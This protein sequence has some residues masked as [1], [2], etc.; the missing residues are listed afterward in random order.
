MTHT[1]SVEC[2][3]VDGVDCVDCTDFMDCVDCVQCG[4]WGVY[5][6]CIG[7]YGLC[8]LFD[9]VECMHG[10][11]CGMC[12]PPAERKNDCILAF[13]RTVGYAAL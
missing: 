12:G 10:E 1:T 11:E 8:C 3:D 9:C 4:M 13:T 7:S 6:K 2:V 5:L